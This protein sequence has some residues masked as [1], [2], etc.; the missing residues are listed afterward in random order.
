[1][2]TSTDQFNE[3]AQYTRIVATTRTGPR[4]A[5]RVVTVDGITRA[6][7]ETPAFVLDRAAYWEAY[8]SAIVSGEQVATEA[9]RAKLGPAA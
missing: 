9:E 3:V 5:W 6:V 7:G 2:T 4:A 8:V 1:M